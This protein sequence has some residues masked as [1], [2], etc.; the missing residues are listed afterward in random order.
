MDTLWHTRLNKHQR[1]LMKYM[2]YIVND[3]TA[4]LFVVIASG[5]MHVYINWIQ[6]TTLSIGMLKLIA[7]AVCVGSLIIGR[8]ATLTQIA[9]TH[10]LASVGDEWK[11][12]MQLSHRY[13]MLLPIGMQL[14]CG[15]VLIPLLTRVQIFDW[16]GLIL[17]GIVLK[18]QDL[19]WQVATLKREETISQL[20]RYVKWLVF[21][22]VY[23][24]S[25]YTFIWVGLMLSVI[26]TM[27]VSVV[28]YKNNSVYD[29][30]K[31][32]V[33][34]LRRQESMWRSIQW[35]V[36]V[37][38]YQPRVKSQKYLDVL[39]SASAKTSGIYMM[40]RSLLRLPQMIEPMIWQ[41]VVGVTVYYLMPH[42]YTLVGVSVALVYMGTLHMI[43]VYRHVRN[44]H[45]LL[46]F[47]NKVGKV[48]VIYVIKRYLSMQFIFLH[49]G[50]GL[51]TPVL[52]VLGSFFLS[53][54]VIYGCLPL[55]LSRKIDK[56][57]NA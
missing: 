47:P 9:D 31:I 41:S 37:P 22:S 48:D 26:T 36:D 29:V 35:F 2:R 33:T 7:C 32:V 13:S 40:E 28:L 17:I 6:H 4:L 25:I 27:I 57:K 34:E 23:A 5:L 39:F 11:R 42:V 50:A 44:M 3:H 54:I 18:W 8:I 19:H 38:M 15:V 53:I 55:Y 14:L 20:R 52:H 30:E 10:F 43:G 46:P 1:L 56:M 51:I 21:S 45:Q 12:Y 16:I 24:F 49:V